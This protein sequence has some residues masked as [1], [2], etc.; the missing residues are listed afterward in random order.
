MNSTRERGRKR[1]M[2]TKEE[3]LGC[4]E[5]GRGSLVFQI[6]KTSILNLV[7]SFPG[8]LLLD[9]ILEGGVCFR[10][11]TN[12]LNSAGKHVQSNW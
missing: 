6:T 12:I 4:G 10:R 3:T 5:C 9:G 7:E 11:G 2:K 8:L 1:W